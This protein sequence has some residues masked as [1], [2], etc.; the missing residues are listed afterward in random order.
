MIITRSSVIS[1]QAKTG[2]PIFNQVLGWLVLGKITDL[3]C[4]KH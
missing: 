1:L 4:V 2:L 3:A